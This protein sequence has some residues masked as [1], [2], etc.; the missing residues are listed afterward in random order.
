MLGFAP[1]LGQ[2]GIR[3]SLGQFDFQPPAETRSEKVVRLNQELDDIARSYS[4]VHFDLPAVQRLSNEASLCR[5]AI[6]KILTE[7]DVASAESSANTCLNALRLMAKMEGD[8]VYAASIAGIESAFTIEMA[9]LG[10]LVLASIGVSAY[11]GYKRNKNS[12]GWA[13]G[14]GFMGLL[15]PVVTPAVAIAEGYA[16]PMRK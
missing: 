7:A 3:P 1:F 10:T 13:A 4:T 16:K 2:V 14:W 15:F 11:H 8:S 6:S 12:I 5:T 9:I